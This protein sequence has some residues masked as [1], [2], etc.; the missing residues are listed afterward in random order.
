MKH[1]KKAGL[2]TAIVAVAFLTSAL[3][4]ME[5]PVTTSDEVRAILAS[6]FDDNAPGCAVG[7]AIN[8]KTLIRE[9]YGIANLDYGIPISAETVF[10]VGSVG[11]QFAAAAIVLLAIDKRIDIAADVREYIPELIQY[12]QPISVYQLIVHTSGIRDV[13]DLMALTGVNDQDAFTETEILSLIGRQRT[14]NFEPGS[15]FLYSNSGYL[16]LAG[17]V[18]NVTGISIGDYLE[19]TLFAPLGMRNT[20]VYEDR[21]RVVENRAI[22]YSRRD[23]GGYAVDH[24]YNF[25][26]G[27]DGQVYT[28]IDDLLLWSEHL[29]GSG[30]ETSPFSITM[31][32]RGCLANGAQ[33][34]YGFGLEYETYRGANVIRHDGVWGGFRAV[35]MRFVDQS[36]S[37]AIACNLSAM[38]PLRIAR[39]IAD[40]YLSEQLAPEDTQTRLIDGPGSET[41]RSW[42]ARSEGT[43]IDIDQIA[44]TYFSEELDVEY[45]LLLEA[46]KLAVKFPGGG[47]QMFTEVGDGEFH[48]VGTQDP[49]RIV[50]DS[51]G[52]FSI[53]TDR[54]RGIRFLRTTA[55]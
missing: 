53:S 20:F 39:Q 54:L 55:N 10:D 31:L 40:R 34:D 3:N 5:T 30:S 49:M 33:I 19:S 21:T 16:L 27:G 28:T 13:F 32:Q 48:S 18:R 46:D 12:Q 1:G 7:V 6:Q 26:V 22:G 29:F 50:Y 41:R 4:A 35:H 25:T 42:S 38:E 47:K 2:L 45:E 36:M 9:G 44:G 43:S 15:E 24:Y 51:D 52:V 23:N 11:K 17:I 37:I 8:G 14:L